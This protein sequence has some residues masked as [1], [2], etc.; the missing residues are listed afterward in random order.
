ML[1]SAIQSKFFTQ[2]DEFENPEISDAK[3]TDIFF[4][5]STE[6]FEELMDK[7]QIDNSITEAVLPIVRREVVA[8]ANTIILDTQ[9]TDPYQRLISV[10]PTFVVSGT[11][12]SFVAEPN[13]EEQSNNSFSDAT[14]RYPAYDLYS[15]SSD[16]KVLLILPTTSIPTTIEVRYFSKPL[17]IDFSTPAVD[18]PY[19]NQTI[20]LIIAKALQVT[21]AIVREDSYFQT[22][23]ALLAQTKTA[24][25]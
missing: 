15:N 7:Y 23:S 10:K 5:A 4:K 17:T 3:L 11:T 24:Q 21:A 2:F 22:Q 1:T 8:G 14:T 18:I 25:Q 9:L 16:Q 13:I 6:V 12:H 20:D 19:P